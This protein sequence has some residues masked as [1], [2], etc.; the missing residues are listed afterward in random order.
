MSLAVT[1]GGAVTVTAG[2]PPNQTLYV[3]NLN[4]KVN[5]EVL[6]RTLLHLFSPYGR[7][8]AVVALK[9]AKMR[10]QAHVVLEG[11]PQATGAMR[12]LQGFVLFE[13]GMRI[14][15]AKTIS[16]A[17]S[18]LEGKYVPPPAAVEVAARKKKAKRTRDDSSDEDDDEDGE[19]RKRRKEGED[20]GEADMETEEPT[21]ASAPTTTAAL[22]TTTIS[23]VAATL[24]NRVLFVSNL[25]PEITD[26]MLG[27]LFQQYAGYR[28][29]RMVPGKT[30]I[31]FVE[32]DTEG[33]AG[34]AKSVLDGFMLTQTTKMKVEFAKRA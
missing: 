13:K 26:E 5:K 31:A 34:T 21:P 27:F 11:I 23:S 3:T 6:R 30:D 15:Y 2:I 25:P 29:V 4:D 9:T 16:N 22:T 10:G 28:E 12:G 18:L 20:D 1:S 17:V 8:I 33:Q 19:G 24:P 14:S 32:Y 7:V